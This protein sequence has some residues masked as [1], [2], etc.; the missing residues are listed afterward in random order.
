MCFFVHIRFNKLGRNA[1]EPLVITFKIKLS[2]LFIEEKEKNGREKLSGFWL[3]KFVE[4]ENLEKW[5]I[6]KFR[7]FV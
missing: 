1:V 7:K 3:G 5:K 2:I 4:M 6:C